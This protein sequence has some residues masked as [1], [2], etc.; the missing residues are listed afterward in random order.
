MTKL[1]KRKV[2]ISKPRLKQILDERK[3]KTFLNQEVFYDRYNDLLYFEGPTVSLVVSVLFAVLDYNHSASKDD[4]QLFLCFF[5]PLLQRQASLTTIQ[6]QIRAHLFRKKHPVKPVE[7]IIRKRAALCIQEWW[8]NLCLRKRVTALMNIKRHISQI[9][10]SDI[11]IEETIY[12][13]INDVVAAARQ[14]FRFREQEIMIDFNPVTFGICMQVDER[15]MTGCFRYNQLSVPAWFGVNL[16]PPDFL[17]TPYVNNMQAFFHF[18]KGDCSIH[19]ATYIVDYKKCKIDIDRNVYFVKLSCASVE[20][21][22]KRAVVMAYLTYD[23]TRHQFV[24][25]HT[26]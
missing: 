26:G 22:R 21:A 24:K 20:E 4:D 18:N 19:P 23:M 11:Y 12:E 8:R 16:K 1:K 14:G 6:Q 2:F 7:L 3:K 15:A 13:N 17:V 5:R 10:S 9:N 25:V